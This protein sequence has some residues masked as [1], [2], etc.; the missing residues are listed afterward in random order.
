MWNNQ[1]TEKS[2]WHN[3]ERP[4][5]R[6]CLLGRDAQHHHHSPQSWR[7]PHLQRVLWC[8]SE[9][10][11]AT[12]PSWFAE[13]FFSFIHIH[14]GK[15]LRVKCLNFGQGKQMGEEQRTWMCVPT[16]RQ[17]NQESTERKHLHLTISSIPSN[18]ELSCWTTVKYFC[19]LSK[20][21]L[22]Q[23]TDTSSSPQ[24]HLHPQT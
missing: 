18:G 4:W 8:R 14:E 19:F 6:S 5:W 20:I 21:H 22:W 7:G 12:E 16:G 3:W 10:I 2:G 24:S 1:K 17:R 15:I 23:T 9:F 11:P 13:I